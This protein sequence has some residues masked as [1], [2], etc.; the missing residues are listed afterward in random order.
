MEQLIIVLM[1]LVFTGG[2]MLVRWLKKRSEQSAPAGER[3]EEPVDVLEDELE[4][5]PERWEPVQERA[6]ASRWEAVQEAAAAPEPLRIPIESLEPARGVPLARARRPAALRSHAP[7][8]AGGVPI[9]EWLR[10]SED[11]KRGIVLMSVLGP[12]KGLE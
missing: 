6:E 8:R 12:C 5:E 10:N 4:W 2:D 11:A 9:R 3:R 7:G 1:I